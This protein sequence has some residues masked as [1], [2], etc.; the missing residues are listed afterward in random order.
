MLQIFPITKEDVLKITNDF[1]KTAKVANVCPIWS[2][3]GQIVDHCRAVV[4]P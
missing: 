2:H 1:L 3:L 4:E